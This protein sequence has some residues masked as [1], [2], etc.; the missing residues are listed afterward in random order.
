MKSESNGNDSSPVDLNELAYQRSKYQLPDKDSPSIPRFECSHCNRVLSTKQSLIEHS[1]IHTG[2]KPYKCSEPGCSHVFRQ[3]SQLSY[4]KRIHLELKKVTE[5]KEP[6]PALPRQE[7][8]DYNNCGKLVLN[9]ETKINL[10]SLPNL[11]ES[12]ESFEDKP[13]FRFYSVSN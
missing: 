3:S 6:V 5:Q 10:P 11:Q 8:M 1:Y 12:S 2:E 9:F 13:S 7:D 4:H